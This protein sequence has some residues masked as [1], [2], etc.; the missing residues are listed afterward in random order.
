M[1]FKS[2]KYFLSTIFILL[3]TVLASSD[4]NIVPKK[5]P[6][7]IEENNLKKITSNFIFPKEKPDSKKNIVVKKQEKKIKIV[8]HLSRRLRHLMFVQMLLLVPKSHRIELS[9]TVQKNQAEQIGT[10]V[11]NSKH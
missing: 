5:K 1:L 6:N 10:I 4:A 11:Q 9:L 2:L 8:R 7:L 3:S